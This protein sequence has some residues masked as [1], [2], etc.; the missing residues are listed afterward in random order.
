M[1]PEAI[2]ALLKFNLTDDL[3]LKLDLAYAATNQ[4]NAKVI[5][6][7]YGAFSYRMDLNRLKGSLK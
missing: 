6:K 4:V 7:N 5:S 1:Q 3:K 2:G